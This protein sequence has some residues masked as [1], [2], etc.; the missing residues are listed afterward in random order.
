MTDLA[1]MPGVHPYASHAPVF[2]VDD[3]H[4][5]ELARDLLRL[6]VAEGAMGLRTM[7]LHLH[8]IGPDSD[9]SAESLSYLDGAILRLGSTIDVNIGPPAGERRIFHGTVSA[10]EAV[11]AEG[12]VPMVAVYAEDA[13]MRLRIS[14]RTARYENM[15]DEAIV[16]EVA[17]A[18][19]LAFKG[20]G[21]N[22]PTNPLVQ[23][24]EQSDLAFVRDRAARLNA[25]VWVD[26]DDKI[27]LA[28][29]IERPGVEVT[30]VQGNELVAAELRS[31][32]AHQRSKVTYRG[33]DDLAVEAVEEAAN[34]EIVRAETSGGRTGPEV[35]A[36]IFPKSELVR[37]RR[38]TITRETAVAYA[39]AE[40]QRR[41]RTFV[42][43]DGTT[44]GT[45]DLVPGTKLVLWRVGTP[46]EGPGYRCTFAQ[47]SYDPT[48]GYR[49]RF[50]AER[51]V[52]S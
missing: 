22:G 36:E 2:T 8:A 23:Q 50:R 29:P 44:N 34:G 6:D 17:A 21:A 32:V 43:V 28:A 3:T 15:T 33:W 24:W 38:D 14:E 25:E 39:R 41:A 51:P 1:S 26:G 4:H 30:L 46:F 52:M 47:H 11:F 27:H 9:G 35:V 12:A 37:A 49:T 40:M 19:G 42:T 48:M 5:G 20:H 45:P 10:V 31:D 13:L 7:V 16:R 18:H